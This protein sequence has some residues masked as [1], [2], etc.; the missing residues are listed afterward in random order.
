[1]KEEKA[2]HNAEKEARKEEGTKRRRVTISG[3]PMG[4]IGAGKVPGSL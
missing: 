4:R 2:N 3:N 1:M